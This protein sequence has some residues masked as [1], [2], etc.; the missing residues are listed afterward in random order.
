MLVA[1]D[2]DLKVPSI[3]SQESLRTALNRL[4]SLRSDQV[5]V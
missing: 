1:A 3:N 5:R 2:G 4:G